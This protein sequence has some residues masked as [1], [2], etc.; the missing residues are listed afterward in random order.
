MRRI[1]AV[2]LRRLDLV[3]VAPLVT[4]TGTHRRRP[5]VLVH[6]ETEEGGGDGECDA[7]AEAEATPPSTPTGRRPSSPN[8][9]SRCSSPR[10]SGRRGRHGGRGARPRSPSFRATRWR[11]PPS[12]WR[13]ST[14]S[15]APSGRSLAATLGVTRPTIPAGATVGIGGISSVVA[16]ARAAV[17]AGYRRVKLK[18]APGRDVGPLV[19]V[20][21]EL[22]DVDHRRRRQ[23]LLRPVEPGAPGGAP[24]AIDALGLAAI[25]QP[26]AA[27][28]LAGSA[29][30]VAELATPVVLDESIDSPAALEAALAAGACSRRGGEARPSR[31]DRRRGAGPR[32]LRRRRRAPVDRGDARGGARA[33]CRVDRRRRASRIRPAGRSRELRPLLPPRHHG[34]ARA[35]RRRSF[36]CR[37]APGLGVEL[38]PEVVAA[39]TARCRVFRPS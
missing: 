36:P 34:A 12:R 24:V 27:G 9:S 6:V 8:A 28:D 11:R 33:R 10:R 2:E 21:R 1:Q 16:A 18:I 26:L 35:R 32:R 25:E 5:V 29:R 30:L 3:L 31:G 38:D 22:P 14:P 4:A 7:L 13:C 15:C 37:R 20:R 19:A 39:A 23:R 17:A